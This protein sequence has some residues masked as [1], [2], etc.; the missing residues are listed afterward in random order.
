MQSTEQKMALVLGATGG[1]GGAVAR[2]LLKRGW[3]IKALTR[4]DAAVSGVVL[5]PVDDALV[6]HHV[7]AC[8]AAD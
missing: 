5:A 8:R 1:I 3:H 4:D 7:S 6:S 2:N